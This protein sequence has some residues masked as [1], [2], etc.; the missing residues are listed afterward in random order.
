MIANLSEGKIN[1]HQLDTSILKKYNLDS[2][3]S[4]EKLT[5]KLISA[6]ERDSVG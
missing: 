4:L 2:L 3:E 1:I 5:K 6:Y